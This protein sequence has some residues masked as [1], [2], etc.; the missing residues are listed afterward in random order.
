M[1]TGEGT[2]VPPGEYDWTCSSFSTPESTAQTANRSLQPLLH[3]SRQKVP[4][5]YNGGPIPH[6]IACS[7]GGIGIPSISWFLEPDWAH[8]PNCITICSAI[9]AQVTAECP[10]TL[11]LALL[12]SKLPLPTGDLDPHVRHDSLDPSEPTDQMASLSVQPFLY[13]WPQCPCTLQWDAP[14]TRQNCPFAWGIWTPI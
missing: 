7:R 1:P 2:L 13:R 9:F 8:N 4:T 6:K 5:V 12:P 11:H 3:S 10:Y 14:S